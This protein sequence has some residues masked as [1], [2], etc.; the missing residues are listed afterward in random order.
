MHDD[1]H[2]SIAHTCMFIFHLCNIPHA[3]LRMRCAHSNVSRHQDA[4]SGLSYQHSTHQSHPF[5]NQL[6]GWKDIKNAYTMHVVRSSIIASH[7]SF[8]SCH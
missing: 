1:I 4:M 2:P 7:L 8:V 3:L 6:S 5:I